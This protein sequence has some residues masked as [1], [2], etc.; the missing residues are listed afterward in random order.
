[1]A[2]IDL[3]QA[4]ILYNENRPVE[5]KR[6]CLAAFDYFRDSLPP[7][8]ALLCR[9]LLARLH[10]RAGERELALAECRS[11]LDRL[12]T[13]DAPTLAFQ[14]N[15]L[16]GQ[17]L[18]TMGS[19][20]RL[21]GVPER[22][23]RARDA[24]RQPAQRGAQDRVR[25]Q[26]ARGLRAPG[27][28]L[29]GA[30]AASAGLAE[31]FGYM[32]QAKSRSLIDLVL[33]PL[34]SL[35]AA[36]LGPSEAVRTIRTLRE[37]LNWYYSLIERDGSSPSAAPP[38][39]SPSSRRPAEVRERGLLRPPPRAPA[40]EDAEYASLHA[41]TTVPMAAIQEALPEGALLVEYFR[42]EDRFV[43]ALV[44]RSSLE[45]HPV[46]GA[47]GVPSGFACCGSSSRSS[48]SAPTTWPRLPR[49]PARGHQRAPPGALPGADRADPRPHAGR[50]VIF[51]PHDALHQ[52]PL[53][54]LYDGE[55]HLIDS[56]SVSYAPSATLYALCHGKKP[57]GGGGSLVL[58]VPDPRAPLIRDE[59]E[60]VAAVVP[61]SDLYFGA[62]AT[63]EVLRA[64]GPTTRLLHLASH[65]HFRQ[66][67]PMFSGIRLGDGYLNLY[68]LYSLR[69]PAEL[70]TLS[71]CST[72]AGVVSG[73]DEVRGLVRGLIYAGVQ[74]MLLTLWDVH[75]Q[76]TAEFMEGFY[77]GLVRH[78]DKPRALRDAMLDLRQRYPHPITGRR[79]RSPAR[80]SR[81][82]ERWRMAM[83]RSVPVLQRSKTKFSRRP[84]FSSPV[85]SLV[86]RIGEARGGGGSSVARDFGV[87][88]FAA[89]EWADFARGAAPGE[90]EGEMRRHLEAGCEECAA[91]L[92]LWTTVHAA[93]L[94]EGGYR[95][96]E[97]ALRIVRAAFRVRQ[98]ELARKRSLARLV[99]DSL[100]QP[101]ALGL[102]SQAVAPR[103]QLFT[104]GRFRID[105]RIEPT[106][107][108]GARAHVLVGQVIE[109]P[110]SRPAP[111]GP[112]L[113]PTVLL[114]AAERPLA[115][116][117]ANRYGE[118]HL[119][120][121][122][123][124]DL[125]LWVVITDEDPI[126]IQLAGPCPTPGCRWMET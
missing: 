76:S 60:T 38:S 90:I 42:I 35:A 17:V 59:V 45:I 66:D 27:R 50:H 16:H 71:G 97:G 25:R 102:R 112:G 34:Q 13:L 87:R 103:Q 2:L 32:E 80:C 10:F 84:I 63:E 54:A 113:G 69:L 96:P 30:R 37:E 15:L 1:M 77:R 93:A 21:P 81:P 24:A 100:T 70:A 109:R 94:R 110:S 125:R 85:G 39:A 89:E 74:T 121:E 92:R 9:L 22:A 28:A 75:D 82:R 115:A 56:F 79:S 64:K 119:E 48:G 106:S 116:A 118:F 120:F 47:A 3:Y 33:Q 73:G 117:N 5:A 11:T 107:G 58:G 111:A 31:A 61:G 78:G 86:R 83:T 114:Y 65:G 101:L 62:D 99:F 67:S 49:R 123:A 23:G 124:E 53:H 43:A 40:A 29:P 7:N 8:K 46:A 18:L 88:H 19:R 36:D 104:R 4:L 52:A 68:D 126:Q 55:R 105:I 72:G 57:S 44:T 12:Q 98:S 26:P 95:P 14:A 6:L 41:P 51:V 91:T 20:S 108:P 122:P